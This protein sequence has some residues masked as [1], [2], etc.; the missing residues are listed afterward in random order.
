MAKAKYQGENVT[1][2][3][4][5]DS[6]SLEKLCL[7]NKGAAVQGANSRARNKASAEGMKRELQI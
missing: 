4:N 3:W 7:E 1:L 5:E 6:L 2:G